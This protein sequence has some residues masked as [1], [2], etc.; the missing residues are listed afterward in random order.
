LVSVGWPPEEDEEEE[1]SFELKWT[2]VMG[3]D[4]AGIGRKIYLFIH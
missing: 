1:E 3:K 4:V 2:P